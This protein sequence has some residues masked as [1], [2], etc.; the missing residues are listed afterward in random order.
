MSEKD[1]IHPAIERL[2]AYNDEAMRLKK[3]QREWAEQVMRANIDPG[4]RLTA[5]AYAYRDE[6]QPTEY[7]R[8]R[9]LI[10]KVEKADTAGE[11]LHCSDEQWLWFSPET[12][13][14]ALIEHWDK[15]LY[16]DMS[17]L[18][19]PS[20]LLLEEWLVDDP[21]RRLEELERKQDL[22][23]SA[24]RRARLT[25]KQAMELTAEADEVAEARDKFL[26]WIKEWKASPRCTPRYAQH[27]DAH[28]VAVAGVR[29]GIQPF[30]VGI[31]QER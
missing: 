23:P 21:S 5:M 24:S 1:G 30:T 11:W 8:L 29:S 12:L 10:G 16:D 14:D 17:T 18:R 2:Q 3:E 6:I 25:E 4:A 19:D 13:C 26:G 27:R 22:R 20:Y 28:P 9:A 7:Y 31:Q 15:D